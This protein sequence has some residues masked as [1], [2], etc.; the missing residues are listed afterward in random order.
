[1]IYYLDN[2]QPVA[3]WCRENGVPYGSA[4]SWLNKGLL[5]EDAC[6]LAKEGHERHKK[7]KTFMLG[8]NTLSKAVDQSTY[9][10]LVRYI[11][12]YKLSVEEAIELYKKRKG[13]K[14]KEVEV[15]NTNTGQVFSSIKE[16]AKFYNINYDNLKYAIRTHRGFIR[17][18]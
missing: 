4:L 15:I 9:N 14:G 11:N 12:S 13:K 17:R 3:D 2:G 1:M 8:N 18:K 6:R 16:C 7:R 10:T 5:V